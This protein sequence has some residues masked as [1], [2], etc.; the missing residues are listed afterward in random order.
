MESGRI[1][2]AKRE[3]LSRPKANRYAAHDPPVAT[4]LARLGGG[5]NIGHAVDVQR[6]GGANDDEENDG[7]AGDAADQNVEPGV[8][9]LLGA[10]ALLD[11]ACLQIEKLP[12]A[13]WWCRPGR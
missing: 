4:G 2:A 11:E 5:G 1:D 6:G 10:Y 8:L 9:V 3:A 7:H 13:R 12:R